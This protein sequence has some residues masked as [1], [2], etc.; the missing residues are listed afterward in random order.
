[1]FGKVFSS[2]TFSDPGR[3]DATLLAVTSAVTVDDQLGNTEMLSL[4]YSL[5]EL[6]PDDVDFFTAPVLGTGT[7]GAASVVYLDG[8]V[9]ERMWDYLRTGSLSQNAEEFGAQA[10][11]DLPR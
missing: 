1:M 8:V 3:L 6:T 11:P 10:L 2:D 4:A 7:E 5:R 9:G